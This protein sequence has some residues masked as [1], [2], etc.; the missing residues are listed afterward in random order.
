MVQVNGNVPLQNVNN[1]LPYTI[2]MHFIFD[3]MVNEEKNLNLKYTIFLY[4]KGVTPDY[5]CSWQ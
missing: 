3:I 2:N 5:T 4:V 1:I